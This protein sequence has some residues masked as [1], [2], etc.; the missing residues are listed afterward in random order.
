MSSNAALAPFTSNCAASTCA[1]A[2]PPRHHASDARLAA[3]TLTLTLTLTPGDALGRQSTTE[4]TTSLGGARLL[5]EVG[6]ESAR[7]VLLGNEVAQQRD[8]ELELAD[9]RSQMPATLAG[10]AS[11]VCRQCQPL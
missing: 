9:L 11:R 6:G 7:I 1:E 3:L 8:L 4:P 2:G 5:G 10:N